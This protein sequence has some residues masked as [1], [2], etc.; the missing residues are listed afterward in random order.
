MKIELTKETTFNGTFFWVKVDEFIVGAN[1][2]FTDSK[3]QEA[4]DYLDLLAAYYEKHGNLE[5]VSE[6]LVTREVTYNPP[7]I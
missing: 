5:N 6:T 4:R 1:K 3:E 2:C 7:T